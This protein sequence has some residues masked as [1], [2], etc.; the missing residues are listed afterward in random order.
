FGFYLSQMKLYHD[1][2]AE[3]RKS[4][5]FTIN[6]TLLILLFSTL[7]PLYLFKWDY[8]IIKLLFT[9]PINYVAYREFLFLAIIVAVAA[10]MIS[11]FFITSEN[12]KRLQIYNFLKLVLVN[13]IVIYAMFSISGDQVKIRLEF[14]YVVELCLI[15][16]FL[17]FYFKH[18]KPNFNKIMLKKAFK[19]GLPAMLTSLLSLLYNFSDKFILEKY[20]TFSDLAVYNLGFT[21]ASILAMI[22][23]SFHTVYL[24]FFYKEKEIAKSVQKTKDIVWRMSGIFFLLSICIWIGIFGMLHYNII[25]KKYHEVIYFLPILLIAQ[26]IQSVVQLFANYIVYFEVVYV[27]TIIVFILSIINVGCN[28]LLIPHYSVYGASASSLLISIISLIIY[29]NYTK[30]KT[31]NYV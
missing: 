28:L 15:I 23:S 31:L 14:S 9:H 16:L 29:Y 12:I 1:Y 6:I 20:G 18:M 26:N 24:P 5:V 4:L 7:V 30:R 22:F 13:G 19:I 17:P 10:F 11:N 2:E 3:E 27:G 21:L 25:D 8:G